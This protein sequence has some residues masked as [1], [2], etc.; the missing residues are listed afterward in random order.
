MTARP[1]QQSAQLV[2]RAFRLLAC[3]LGVWLAVGSCIGSAGEKGFSAEEFDSVVSRLVD[4]T[5]DSASD[6]A[7]AVA[8]G[9]CA[10]ASPDSITGM[11]VGSS[12][13]ANSAAQGMLRFRERVRK[14]LA[15]MEFEAC[16]RV[17]SRTVQRDTWLRHDRFTE[18]VAWKGDPTID[19]AIYVPVRLRVPVWGEGAR[20]DS[21]W[22]R[23]VAAVLEAVR[24]FLPDSTRPAN[25]TPGDG[26][27]RKPIVLSFTTSDESYELSSFPA[28]DESHDVS[29]AWV[30]SMTSPQSP[31]VTT[32][33]VGW[34]VG[35][36][37]AS[38]ARVPFPGRESGL[39]VRVSDF[40][41]G[42]PDVA[43]CESGERCD[44][45][46]P[47]H[48]P[49]H[50]HAVFFPDGVQFSAAEARRM[51]E[52]TLEVLLAVNG[53]S[54]GDVLPV[55]RAE[56][57]ALQWWLLPCA[58]L[59]LTVGFAFSG[60]L[61]SFDAAIRIARRARRV[62]GSNRFLARVLLF[63]LGI[64]LSFR[65]RFA[66][67]R[68]ICGSKPGAIAKPKSHFSEA[69]EALRFWAGAHRGAARSAWADEL[70]EKG[71]VK[72]GR[73]GRWAEEADN[74]E[75]W[76]GGLFGRMQNCKKLL[77]GCVREA[78]EPLS[79]GK[80]GRER[81]ARISSPLRCTLQQLDLVKQLRREAGAAREV[82]KKARLLAGQADRWVT[83]VKTR[84]AAAGPA[85]GTPGSGIRKAVEARVNAAQAMETVAGALRAAAKALRWEAKALRASTRELRV[86][87]ELALQRIARL[88]YD[89]VH[90]ALSLLITRLQKERDKRRD[91]LATSFSRLGRVVAS[92]CTLD[93]NWRVF[94]CGFAALVAA[95]HG[96]VIRVD[97]SILNVALSG[98]SE[99]VWALVYVGLGTMVFLASALEAKEYSM[100]R[101]AGDSLR[102][103]KKRSRRIRTQS[104]RPVFLLTGLKRR[105]QWACRCYVLLLVVIV[106]I[107]MSGEL[108][109]LERLLSALRHQAAPPVNPY[110]MGRVELNFAILLVLIVAFSL[111]P[112]W[113]WSH[114][115]RVPQDG[116]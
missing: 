23:P 20:P 18:L 98:V 62:T 60:L 25:R 5:A 86:E 1:R 61:G 71:R 57:R 96:F 113:V 114:L 43:L 51:G 33:D 27:E 9:L 30:G 85:S 93:L 90:N 39:P 55:S 76:R 24:A 94:A 69:D 48:P 10:G 116:S 97:D 101:R 108:P 11:V 17:M 15:R 111:P 35:R 50:V 64:V 109:M 88:R 56:L 34:M 103:W 79:K 67:K 81:M 28:A 36:L 4:E 91:H 41:T 53:L 29:A 22:V 70:L 45:I 37:R 107:A 74:W 95:V 106:L 54:Y 49:V 66:S 65:H 89:T 102:Y 68:D 26:A 63:A 83:K 92:F 12:L 77:Q 112:L 84:N 13:A 46:V 99:D 87:A 78:E 75:D 31:R 82:G 110:A 19:E 40:K 58:L 47:A 6:S 100:G 38:G 104:K 2:G 105:L 52:R 80:T 72:L 7:F 59:V 73:I 44:L 8:D 14:E 21:S 3:T 32:P 42:L 16:V 115:K